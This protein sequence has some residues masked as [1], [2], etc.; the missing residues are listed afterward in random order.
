MSN[1]S[2]EARLHLSKLL[3]DRTKLALGSLALVDKQL[4]EIHTVLTE[5]TNI[6]ILT[7]QGEEENSDSGFFI[8][9]PLE[10]YE[11]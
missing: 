8:T 3:F 4:L 1:D 9:P 7:E 5:M 10:V 2:P 11:S 6:D